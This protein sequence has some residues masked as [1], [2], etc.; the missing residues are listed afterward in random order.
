M[1]RG[2][3][4]PNRAGHSATAVG[5]YLFI[6]GGASGVEY[7]QDIYVLDTDPPPTIG[8]VSPDPMSMLLEKIP[9]LRSGDAFYDV[10]FVVEGRP[11]HAHRVFLSLLS[12]R[13]KAMFTDGFLEST[14]REVIVP[15]TT[16]EAFRHL[17]SY[18]YS[19]SLPL[20]SQ[21][22][23]PHPLPPA[24][25]SEDHT[26]PPPSSSLTSLSPNDEAELLIELLQLSDEYM[27]DHLKQICE[28]RLSEG[29]TN[30]ESATALEYVAERSNAYQ[31]ISTCQ[32][33]LRNLN[34]NAK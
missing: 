16:Y 21:P 20:L 10:T 22:P 19:G 6:V 14:Q 9:D 4:P 28:E 27:I 25:P 1:T 31:L 30:E 34:H 29:I 5:R 11:I 24:P 23:S 2:S 15:N 3:G 7:F 33:F 8:V 26:H 18:L 13:F 12:D 32:H 17:I